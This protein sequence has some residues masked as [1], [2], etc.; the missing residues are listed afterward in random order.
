MVLGELGSG[1]GWNGLGCRV[2][3]AGVLGGMGWGGMAGV[4]GGLCGGAQWIGQACRV[5]W[6]LVEVL[7]GPGT[8]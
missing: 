4:P 3:W 1:A 5:D 2:E 7:N 8:G 6:V